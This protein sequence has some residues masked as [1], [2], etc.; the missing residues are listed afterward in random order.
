MFGT[1]LDNSRNFV[2]RGRFFAS[3]C[4]ARVRAYDPLTFFFGT[5]YLTN[6]GITAALK[7]IPGLGGRLAGYSTLAYYFFELFMKMDENAKN[8]P[9]AI[10]LDVKK[11]ELCRTSKN[12]LATLRDQK[13]ITR[14]YLHSQSQLSDAEIHKLLDSVVDENTDTLT[15]LH[16]FKL[17]HKI[18]EIKHPFH[19]DRLK[20]LKAGTF[21]GYPHLIEGM[22][23]K[24]FAEVNLF[25]ETVSV[26]KAICM[27]LVLFGVYS[28]YQTYHFTMQ[29]KKPTS[30]DLLTSF[31]KDTGL[32]MKPAEAKETTA[33]L[34]HAA[35]DVKAGNAM[36]QTEDELVYE[37]ATIDAFAP[38]CLTGHGL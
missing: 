15:L 20:S 12:I 2:N 22:L 17:Y 30:Y 37:L 19:P 38:C 1:L 6:G 13:E 32:F 8:H 11:I 35:I 34:P 18:H 3:H 36:S 26:E 21:H 10:N 28:A 7:Y 23:F 27:L 16:L 9:D 5:E 29:Q 31:A 24:A 33:L 25:D 14:D 4:F